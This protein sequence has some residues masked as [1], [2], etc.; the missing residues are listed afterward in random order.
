MC[1]VNDMNESNME[2]DVIFDSKIV[3]LCRVICSKQLKTT[4]KL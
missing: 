3:P 4:T 1:V 2:H